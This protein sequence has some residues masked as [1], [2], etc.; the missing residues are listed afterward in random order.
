ML[1]KLEALVKGT[2][3]EER[4]S[5]ALIWALPGDENKL[6]TALFRGNITLRRALGFN[7]GDPSR[8]NDFE[9]DFFAP[10]N[11]RGIVGPR[12]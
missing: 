12:A 3:R 9:S 1:G 4:A 7:L 5:I 11:C 8:E 2:L 10:F 6:L